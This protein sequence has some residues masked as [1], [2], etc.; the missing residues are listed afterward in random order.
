MFISGIQQV[1]IGVQ[2]A[3]LAFKWYLEHFGMDLPMFEESATAALM[4]PYTGGKPRDRHAIFALN[5]QGGGGMEIWQYTCRSPEAPAFTPE[6]GDLGI[7]I[8]KVKSKNV[9]AS[10]HDMKKRGIDLCSELRTC[11][12]GR[13]HFYTRDP[14]G[15]LFEVVG[16]KEWFHPKLRAHTGGIYG[17]VIGVSDME[18]SL[19]FYKHL[20]GYETVVYDRTDRFNDLDDLSGGNRQ[21][22][23]VLLRHEE[24]RPGPFCRLLGS[25]EIEL[26]QVLDRPPRK[27]FENRFWGD[28]GFIHLCFDVFNMEAL[29]T[30]CAQ[31]GHPFTVD[32]LGSFD[33]G[34][35]TGSFSY[36]EDPDGTLIEFVETHRIPILKKLGV[37]LN[38]KKRNYPSRPLPNLILRALGLARV[39]A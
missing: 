16:S 18:R 6:L 31:K 3:R 1:G 24:P 13:R 2:D 22:R 27:I 38:L 30:Y 23:R 9:E 15:N 25:S 21:L 11:P 4:L 36:I 33:M 10:F 29:R 37:Y 28:L 39:K 14:W 12:D 7:F 17:C 19:P 32:S 5:L 26:V 20:L 35:A 34:E 8:A